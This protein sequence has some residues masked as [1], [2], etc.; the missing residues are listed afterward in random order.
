MKAAAQVTIEVATPI[1]LVGYVVSFVVPVVL[2]AK[3]DRKTP[4]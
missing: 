2:I 3:I 1:F 4:S